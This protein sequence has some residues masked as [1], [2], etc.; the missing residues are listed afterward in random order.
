MEIVSGMVIL[1][2]EGLA[3]K[4][5]PDINMNI[6]QQTEWYLH[7]WLWVGASVVLGL[8]VISALRGHI[9]QKR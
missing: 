9:R 7:P 8:L 2:F 4:N 6:H 3:Q 5:N 1:T